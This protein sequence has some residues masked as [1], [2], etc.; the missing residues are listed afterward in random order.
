MHGLACSGTKC[1][2]PQLVVGFACRNTTCIRLIESISTKGKDSWA[3]ANKGSRK[4][5]FDWIVHVLAALWPHHPSQTPGPCPPSCTCSSTSVRAETT[6]LDQ[7]KSSR[8]RSR[9]SLPVSG[10]AECTKS[11]LSKTTLQA[12]SSPLCNDN[13]LV[14]LVEST[15]NVQYTQYMW[16][17]IFPP[18]CLNTSNRTEP[19]LGELKDLM[20]TW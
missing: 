10:M 8:I 4:V 15:E 17:T 18:S 16:K 3:R 13:L 6:R 11:M 14:A 1:V 9:S 12:S 19:T 7:V 2:L 20:N 5:R